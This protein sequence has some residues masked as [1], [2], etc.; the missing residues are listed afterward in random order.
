MAAALLRPR[1]PDPVKP[2][3][4]HRLSDERQLVQALAQD[5]AQRLSA[6]VAE[7]GTALLAVS[8]GKSPVALFQALASHPVLASVWPHITVLLVDERCVPFNHADS[9]SRLVHEHLLQGAASGA[10]WVPLVNGELNHLAPGQ[11]VPD[12]QRLRQVAEGRLASLP[13]PL[14]VVVLGMGLDAHTA[15][16]FPGAPGLGEALATKARCAWVLPDADLNKASHPRITLSLAS[17]LAARHLYLPLTGSAK[18]KVYAQ[19]LEGATEERPIS[20]LLCQ[21]QNPVSVWLSP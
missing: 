5:I 3:V 6:A 21:T 10:S 4:E 15:S 20:L 2:A 11:P 18:H 8:G 13:W 17:L 1:Q 14:D 7:R 19:A 16:L 12:V 9:N